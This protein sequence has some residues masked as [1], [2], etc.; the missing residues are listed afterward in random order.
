MLGP[1]NGVSRLDFK[2]LKTRKWYLRFRWF[3]YALYVIALPVNAWHASVWATATGFSWSI[4][5]IGLIFSAIVIEI[6]RTAFVSIIEGKK[7]FIP[8]GK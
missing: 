6:I 3:A 5:I 2:Y 1:E 4:F 7:A 8:P